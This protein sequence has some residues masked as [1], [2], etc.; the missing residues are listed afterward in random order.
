MVGIDSSL[1]GTA[2]SLVKEEVLEVI[3]FI[4]SKNARSSSKSLL[5]MFDMLRKA[6][7]R[8]L[9]TGKLVGFKYVLKY[10]ESHI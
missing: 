1:K 6:E 7:N 5:H 10:E 8:K 9:K 4:N 2:F 3:V